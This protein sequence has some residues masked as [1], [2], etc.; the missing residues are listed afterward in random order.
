[1]NTIVGDR[2]TVAGGRRRLGLRIAVVGTLV[3]SSAITVSATSGVADAPTA[4]G[5]VVAVTPAR[6]ADSRAGLQIGSSVPASGSVTV[7]VAGKGGVPS[8]KVASVLLNVTAVTP[9]ASGYLTVWPSG[10]TRSA[11]SSLNFNAGTDVANT[12]I[13]PVGSDGS[14]QLF[15]GS[16]GAVNLVVDVSGYT[17]AGTA[18]T[19]GTMVAVTPARLVDSSTSLQVTG[20]LSPDATTKFQITGRGGV[21]QSGVAAAV[22]NVTAAS[23]D[24]AGYLTAWPSGLPRTPTSSVNFNARHRHRERGRRAGRHRRCDPALQRLGRHRRRAS[25][26]HRLHRGR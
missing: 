2:R 23:P 12:V 17:L 14:I 13:T 15:N 22:L 10:M 21:P 5:S 1:M 18:T 4:A 8:S 25:R 3:L 7:K 26:C 16:A 6:V 9:Q 20:G 24:T 19:P 11:T